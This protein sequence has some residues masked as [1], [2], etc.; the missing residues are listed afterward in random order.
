[1]GVH[2]WLNAETFERV[3]TALFSRFER[4]FTCGDSFVRLQCKH[5]AF[6]FDNT[7]VRTTLV[8]CVI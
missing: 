4:C 5:L 6:I 8:E 7:G 2:L 1:M 3:P